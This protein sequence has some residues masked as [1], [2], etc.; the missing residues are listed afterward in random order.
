MREIWAL[1]LKDLKLLVRD[2]AGLFFT[3]FFPVLYA[4]FFGTIFGGM[5]GGGGGGSGETAIVVVDQ[6]GTDASRE[7]AAALD[8]DS[9]LAVTPMADRAGAEE[10][11]KKGQKTAFIV[12]PEGFGSVSL[13]RG[14]PMKLIVG[15]DP[16]R[17]AEGGLIQGLITAK[18]YERLQSSFMNTDSA[19]EMTRD[20]LNEIAQADDLNPLQKGILNTFLGS[21]DT[22]LE[23]APDAGV[24]GGGDGGGD[25]E[26]STG[27]AAA[28]FNP[29]EIESV[30]LLA[31]ESGE[32]PSPYAITFPQGIIWGIMGCASGFGISLVT[33]RNKGTLTRL[34]TAPLGRSRVLLGKGLACFMTTIG[35]AAMLLVIATLGFGV[36]PGSAPLLAVAVF[37]V[38]VA[39][40]GIMMLLSTVGKTE[41]AAGGIGWA[42][43]L[44]FA[45]L[46]GGML[47]LAFMPAWMA[48]VSHISPVKWS[49][50]AMEGAIWRGFSPADMALPCGI[51]LAV[52]LI[53]FALGARLFDWNEH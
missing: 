25:G 4:I 23:Q 43:M 6:D 34:R 45:M 5:G 44:V 47:P 30:E 2:K 15:V 49:I 12:I 46:G 9:R 53:G 41:A 7:F 8:A 3:F 20:A 13:F 16:S 40:V 35:V 38:A 50:L 21:L 17:Q 18:A 42:V 27:G 32:V 22:F 28:A 19:R 36:R 1:A 14:E 11:V 48:P 33:E 26:D 24:I 31:D 10:A 52:G 51:L 29:I 37:S 39:F